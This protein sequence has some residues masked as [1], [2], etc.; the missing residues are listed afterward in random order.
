MRK[1][2]IVE[3]ESIPEETQIEEDKLPETIAER[4]FKNANKSDDESSEEDQDFESTSFTFQKNDEVVPP[5]GSRILTDEVDLETLDALNT[6]DGLEPFKIPISKVYR[7][8]NKQYLVVDQIPESYISL[9]SVIEKSE[10][11]RIED[12]KIK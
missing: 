3:K 11:E 6:L 10:K 5:Y 1:S 12:G 9:K 7:H 4:R 2:K 8:K